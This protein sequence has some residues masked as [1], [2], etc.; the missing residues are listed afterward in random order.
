MG[1]PILDDKF[2]DTPILSCFEDIKMLLCSWCCACCTLS[3]VR[4][5][6]RGDKEGFTIVEFITSYFLFPCCMFKTRADVR[7]KYDKALDAPIVDQIL[8][9]WCCGICTL[10]QMARHMEKNNDLAPLK[11]SS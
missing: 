6:V 1:L 8:S 3:R 10:S 9:C 5:G 11:L 2:D 7:A 4:A